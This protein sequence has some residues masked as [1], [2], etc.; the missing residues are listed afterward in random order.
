MLKLMVHFVPYHSQND[1]DFKTVNVITKEEFDKITPK[2]EDE[3]EL[4]EVPPPPPPPIVGEWTTQRQGQNSYKCLF[5]K[6]HL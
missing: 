3:E 5:T 2:Y 4:Q 6:C 1:S